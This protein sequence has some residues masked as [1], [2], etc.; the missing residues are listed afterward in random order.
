[1]SKV[2]FSLPDKLVLKMKLTIPAGERSELLANLLEK[3]IEKREET[4]YQDALKLEAY[5][6]LQQEMKDWD[7][8]FGND[9][10]EHV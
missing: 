6:E 3:E 9:G 5:T 8:S 10:L 7:S 1:M 4:F 2:M